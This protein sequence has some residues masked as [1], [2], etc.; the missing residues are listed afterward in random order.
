MKEQRVFLK[1]QGIAG[2]STRPGHLGEIE[3]Y[4]FRLAS[5]AA[6]T[7]PVVKFK[8][9]KLIDSTSPTLLNKVQVGGTIKKGSV[10][11]EMM[12]NLKV[13]HHSRIEIADIEISGMGSVLLD[14]STPGNHLDWPFAPTGVIQRSVDEIIINVGK[15]GSPNLLSLIS[16]LI[17]LH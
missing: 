15:I 1:L 13:I 6:S 5:S 14:Y 9:L 10:T 2:E 7:D 12:E 17:G 11:V 8:F 16:S 4:R 3:I